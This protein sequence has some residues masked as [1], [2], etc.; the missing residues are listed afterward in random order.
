VA[1]FNVIPPAAV[2]GTEIL[3][4]ASRSHDAE[5][6]LEDLEFRWDWDDDLVWDTEFARERTARRRFDEEGTFAIGLEVRDRSGLS[7]TTRQFVHLFYPL[8]CGAA[9]DPPSGPAPLAVTFTAT[10]GGGHGIYELYWSY[11]DGETDTLEAP[12]HLFETPG[13]HRVVLRVEDLVYEQED[14]LD[15]VV[16]QVLAP[17]GQF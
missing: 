16:V 9:A 15:T 6:P 11:E 8:V 12:V 14:C 2:M 4:D 3:V 10:A 5:D 17:A 1:L 13:Q 7:D